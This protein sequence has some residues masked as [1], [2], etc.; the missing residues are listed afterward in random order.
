MFSIIKNRVELEEILN[1]EDYAD[2]KLHIY[3]A[4]YLA[5][6]E[7]LDENGNK[8]EYIADMRYFI[9]SDSKHRKETVCSEFFN[10]V[11]QDEYTSGKHIKIETDAL[12]KV[13]EM[14]CSETVSTLYYVFSVHRNLKRMI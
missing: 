6:F 14:H 11:N 13:I 12:H 1:S 2:K 10:M 3:A 5:R 4:G 9:L 7:Q 8:D